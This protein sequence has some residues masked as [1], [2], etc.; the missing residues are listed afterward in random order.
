MLIALILIG[1]GIFAPAWWMLD[2]V[3]YGQEWQFGLWKYCR[4]DSDIQTD[5]R[6]R[7]LD[8][9]QWICA[10]RVALPSPDIDRLQTAFVD[11]AHDEILGAFRHGVLA[12]IKTLQC[13]SVCAC[14]SYSYA[15]RC[16][17]CAAYTATDT[18]PTACSSAT[19]SPVRLFVLVS[20]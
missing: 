3:E 2:V 19:S 20:S 9:E 1:V 7:S 12:R 13:W 8:S 17:Q 15:Y 18:Y 10:R 5:V 6:A 14:A 11:L 4:R 16:S